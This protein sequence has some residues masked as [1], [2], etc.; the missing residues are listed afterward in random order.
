M[1]NL[2]S[3]DDLVAI[4]ESQVSISKGQ[5]NHVSFPSIELLNGIPSGIE[6][7][8]H[9]PTQ[10]TTQSQHDRKQQ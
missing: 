2:L 1:G 3:S 4:I 7:L 10:N 6:I 5:L 9:M 8:E